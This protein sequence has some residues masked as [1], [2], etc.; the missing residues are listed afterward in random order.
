MDQDHEGFS[1]IQYSEPERASA[2]ALWL[3]AVLSA[4]IV[5]DL[6][7]FVNFRAPMN[8]REYTGWLFLVSPVL[9]GF[10]SGSIVSWKEERTRVDH[11]TSAIYAL[12]TSMAG[13]VAFSL[14]GFICV[15]M[16]LPITIPAVLLGGW[17]SYRLQR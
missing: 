2:G 3:S 5:G 17:L 6:V 16:A 10:L 11:L 4:I 12:V 8:W 7:Y 1:Q 13:M 15:F 9:L 14:E